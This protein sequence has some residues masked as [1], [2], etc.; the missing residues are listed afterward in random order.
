M[1]AARQENDQNGLTAPSRFDLWL[2]MP[3]ASANA[4]TE[5]KLR[6][7]QL[8]SSV[9]GYTH[10]ALNHGVW[11]PSGSEDRYTVLPESI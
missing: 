3:K 11:S 2:Q 5:S 10:A 8:K 9:T 7:V 1:E 6:V 4:G